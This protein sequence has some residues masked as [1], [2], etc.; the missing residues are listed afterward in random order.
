MGVK[1][2]IMMLVMMIV[3][4]TIHMTILM[5]IIIIVIMT[6]FMFIIIIVLIIGKFG[7]FNIKVNYENHSRIKIIIIHQVDPI[8]EIY[9]EIELSRSK[10]VYFLILYETSQGRDVW[11]KFIKDTLEMNFQDIWEAVTKLEKEK[12]IVF[13]RE[14]QCKN[15]G[16]TFKK[17]IPKM[18]NKS[19]KCRSVIINQE[20]QMNDFTKGNRLPRFLIKPSNNN[21][22][23]DKQNHKIGKQSYFLNTLKKSI[24]NSVSEFY[25]EFSW[26]FNPKIFVDKRIEFQIF[27]FICRMYHRA[28]NKL[29]SEFINA[30][31]DIETTVVDDLDSLIRT[32]IIVIINEI[33]GREDWLNDWTWERLV[34]YAEN[35]IHN[36]NLKFKMKY[37]TPFPMNFKLKHKIVKKVNMILLDHPLDYEKSL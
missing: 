31:E 18:C 34:D 17:R 3:L 12:K 1:I 24:E 20:C 25:K 29:Y 10:I 30:L 16:H 8:M 15:C 2:G 27:K 21:I 13:I 19:N 28:D 33:A 7:K 5:N 35:F 36:N 37:L 9:E 14:V 23:N 4:M 26:D 22:S 32:I 11:C 6:I